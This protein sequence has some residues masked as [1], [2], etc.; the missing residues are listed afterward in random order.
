M[1][2]RLLT[3]ALA[4][5][6][7]GAAPLTAQR[8]PVPVTGRSAEVTL[9]DGT[10]LSGE[11]IE[12]TAA[13]LWLVGAEAHRADLGRI[14]RVRVRRHDF[15][16]GDALRWVGIAGVAAGLGMTVA[17][18]QVDGASCGEVFPAV[19]LSFA[20]VGGLFSVG[21]TSSGWRDVPVDPEQLRAYARFPQGAPS[22]FQP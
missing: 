14:E 17:C 16:G 10:R 21:M 5:A 20:L 3:A 1:K 22:G 19:A 12:A 13:G 7:I 15:G 8:L 18:S 2:T 6:L 9:T 4:C 11:L